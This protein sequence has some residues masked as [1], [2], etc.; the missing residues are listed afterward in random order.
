MTGASGF[1]GSTLIPRLAADGH[2]LRALARDPRRG[3]APGVHVV[4]G[5]VV[6][7]TG[8]AAALDGVDVAYYLIHSME[9]ARH[10]QAAGRA[11]AHDPGMAAID[12]FHEL[13]ERG[14]ANF[15]AAA[16]AAEIGRIVYLGGPLPQP[17]SASRHLASRRLVEQILLGAVPGSVALKAS[18]VIGAGS[19]SF[20]LLVRLV[21]RLPVLALPAWRELA[22]EP[23]DIRDVIE[24]LVAAGAREA[25]AGR[26][27]EVGGPEILTYEEMI[28]RIAEIMIVRRPAIRLGVNLTPIV[29]RLA[30][31]IAQEDPDL[32][33]P[34]MES[35]SGDLI[36]PDGARAARLLDVPL[37]SFDS[38]VEHA[39]G[40]WERVEPLAAR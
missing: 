24:M 32:V 27:L 3:A 29:A 9:G 34:L 14:A 37:H 15:A 36:A 12:R 1:I 20:R 28:L 17:G 7:G 19:R 22:T 21:E 31:A 23:I 39:L 5:D 40:E 6:A 30:A 35:L 25:A 38:A 10:H 26:S 11:A 33:L 16:R 8:L 2:E 18:I 13:E 4:Q